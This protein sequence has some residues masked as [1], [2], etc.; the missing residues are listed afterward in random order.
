MSSGELHLKRVEDVEGRI[1]DLGLNSS[2]TKLIP[3]NCVLVGL[4]GQGRT[5]GTVAINLIALCTNQSIAAIFPSPSFVPEYL[6]HN[7]DA[8]YDEL[9]ELSTGDGGRGGLN[10][11]IIKGIEIPFP[12]LEEQKA[13]AAVLSDMDIEL[14]ALEARRTKVKELKQAMMQELLMGKTRLIA[15]E[16]SHV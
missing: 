7:L 15:K 12:S 1:T 4:A 3:A 8:R 13:I 6:F 14:S 9:R 5:R 2:S 16:E 11:K 10:L